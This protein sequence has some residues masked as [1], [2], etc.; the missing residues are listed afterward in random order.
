MS[1]PF[2]SQRAA[3]LALLNSDA[4]LSRKAGSFA[5]QLCVDPTPMSP[6]Q[7]SWLKTLLEKAG[8]PPLADG[9]DHG[10]S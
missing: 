1:D 6:A 9:G 10:L 8:L 3:A 7:Q 5:G 2:T 4:R